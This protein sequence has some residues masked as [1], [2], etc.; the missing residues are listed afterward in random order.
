MM[1]SGIKDVSA[2]VA[3]S[4]CKGG[5]GKSTVAACLALDLAERGYK[6][7][8]FGCGH[9]RSLGPHLV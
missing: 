1:K 7:G 2:F 3:I 5:V 9:L 6:V 8:L 4:S